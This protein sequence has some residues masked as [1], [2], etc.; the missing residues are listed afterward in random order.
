MSLARGEGSTP[1]A[2]GPT[3]VARPALVIAIAPTP[4]DRLR[5]ARTLGEHT[6][7]IIV[8]TRDEAIALLVDNDRSVLHG[9]P[10]SRAGQQPAAPSTGLRIDS[11]LR[12]ARYQDRSVALSPLEHDLLRCLLSELGHTWPFDALHREIWGNGHLGGRG[13]VQSVVKRLRH[14]LHDLRCPLRIVSVRGVGLRLDEG[15]AATAS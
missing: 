13:D 7:L 9:A 11:D 1:V 8:G 2:D 6:A 5:L 14:K 15:P 10:Q 4:Q 12:I 3:S